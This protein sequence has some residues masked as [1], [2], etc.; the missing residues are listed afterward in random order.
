MKV[1]EWKENYETVFRRRRNIEEG[2]K[3]IYSLLKDQ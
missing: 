3:N 1:L 2:N